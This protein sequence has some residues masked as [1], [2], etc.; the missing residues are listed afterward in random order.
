MLGD[1]D[2]DRRSLLAAAI[3]T[4][5]ALVVGRKKRPTTRAAAAAAAAIQHPADARKQASRLEHEQRE[6]GCRHI[7]SEGRV[8]REREARED[9]RCKQNGGQDEEERREGRLGLGREE[10]KGE[11]ELRAD[12]GVGG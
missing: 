11:G 2:E 1:D 4:E 3:E 7:P 6:M 12:R 9:G 8:K 10:D 5:R